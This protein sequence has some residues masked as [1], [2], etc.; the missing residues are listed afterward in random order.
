M[1]KGRDDFSKPVIKMMRDRVVGRC[2]N[3]DCRTPTLAPSGKDKLNNTGVAAHIHAASEGGS[4][5]DSNMTTEER[6]SIHNGLWLCANC[7]SKIDRDDEKYPAELLHKWKALAEET[8]MREQGTRLPAENDAIDILTSAFTGVPKSILSKSIYSVHEANRKALEALD[9]R[10][11]IKSQY[12]DGSSLVQL[13][14]KENIPFTLN[15]K[16]E[17]GKDFISGHKD[18]VEHGRAL[19]IS[20]DLVEVKGSKLIEYIADSRESGSL[21]ISPRKIP[22]IQKI[23]LVNK[24]SNAHTYLE[25]IHGH[26]VFGTK[27]FEF[28]GT[29]LNGMLSYKHICSFNDDTG[30]SDL[31]LNF[32]SWEGISINKIQYFNKLFTFFEEMF[33][34]SELLSSLEVNGEAGLNGTLKDPESTELFYHIFSHLKYIKYSREIS[35][36]FKVDIKYTSSIA[37]TYEHLQY[38]YEVYKTIKGL[39]RWSEKDQKNNGKATVCVENAKEFEKQFMRSVACEV[40]IID[41]EREDIELFGTRITLPTRVFLIQDTIPKI[42]GERKEGIRDGDSIEIEYVPSTNYLCSIIY[43]DDFT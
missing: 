39:N 34:G 8:A 2:S 38:I 27:S 4:R 32:S 13:H 23:W 1:S 41:R 37:Y 14:A 12:I 16:P 21:T 26:I 25:D 11:S 19:T 22:S 33:N 35:Q 40:K 17:G 9:P 10:F 20:T 24:T 30:K 28:T 18:L 31:N 6:K 43:E 36:H 3:P 42:L 5:Y 15:V 7:A 29:A